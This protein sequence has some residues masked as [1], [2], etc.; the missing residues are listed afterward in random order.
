MSYTDYEHRETAMN[1]TEAF[2]QN[3]TYEGRLEIPHKPLAG[4]TGVLGVQAISSKFSALA[5]ED[6][7]FITPPTRTN[8]IG[9][10]GQES[11]DVGPVNVKAG[12]RVEHTSLDQTLL[13]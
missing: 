8:S 5:V 2:F 1:E 3:D 6:S 12:V 4:F 11:V 13:E 10:F 9:I 7:I